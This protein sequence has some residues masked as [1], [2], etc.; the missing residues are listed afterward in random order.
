M[1]HEE[2]KDKFPKVNGILND[3]ISVPYYSLKKNNSLIKLIFEDL[4][5]IGV[6]ENEIK[7]NYILRGGKQRADIYLE[8][9]NLSIEQ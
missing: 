9:H 1:T 3:F 8:N 5:S 7:Y 4:I 6:K 2:F